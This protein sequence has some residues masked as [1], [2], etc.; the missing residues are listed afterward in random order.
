MG[1][2]IIRVVEQLWYKFSI[3]V[4]VQYGVIATR[5]KFIYSSSSLFLS[6]PHLPYSYQFL[7]LS[8]FINFSS[9]FLSIPL[10]KFRYMIVFFGWMNSSTVPVRPFI[11]IIGLDW[12]IWQGRMICERASP[13]CLVF[14]C[15]AASLRIV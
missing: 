1:A 7:F 13:N 10:P 14:D 12:I 4:N 9:L 3:Q 8:K 5:I 2:N 15:W 6:I 11:R